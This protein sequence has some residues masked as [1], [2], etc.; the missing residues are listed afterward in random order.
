MEVVSAVRKADPVK[1]S[2]QVPQTD[3]GVVWTDAKDLVKDMD[4][5]AD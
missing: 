5:K 4:E 1:G 2:W 3:S